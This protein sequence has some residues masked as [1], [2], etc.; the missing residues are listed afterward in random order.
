MECQTDA[1]VL[2]FYYFFTRWFFIGGD[3]NNV[4]YVTEGAREG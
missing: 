1:W 3:V 2:T 4:I